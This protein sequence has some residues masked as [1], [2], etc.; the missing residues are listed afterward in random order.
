MHSFL[1]P[2][3]KLIIANHRPERPFTF[4]SPTSVMAMLHKPDGPFTAPYTFERSCRQLV[5]EEVRNVLKEILPD[6]S[7]SSS[8]RRSSRSGR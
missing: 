5:R 2:F 8:N 3:N 4:E 7:R 1:H 6:R